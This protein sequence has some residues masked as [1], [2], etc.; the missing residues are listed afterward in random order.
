MSF[1]HIW[2]IVHNPLPQSPVSAPLVGGNL[3]ASPY[4]PIYLLLF[5]GKQQKTDHEWMICF[6]NIFHK[7]NAK[8]SSKKEFLNCYRN[9]FKLWNNEKPFFIAFVSAQNLKI[10]VTSRRRSSLNKDSKN[11]TENLFLFNNSTAD[12]RFSRVKE[13]NVG[14]YCPSLKA[15][16][17]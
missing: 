3:S 5:N 17:C 2:F 6:H 9:S 8:S 13:E 14:K 15:G 7:D 16:G 11:K 12:Q 10:L 4:S 1:H